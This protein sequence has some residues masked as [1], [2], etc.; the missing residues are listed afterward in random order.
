[1]GIAEAYRKN[2]HAIVTAYMKA[3]G[4]SLG[5]VSRKFH[6]NQAF[7]KGFFADDESR[8]VSVTIDKAEEMI[9]TLR[10]AWPK[11]VKWP[12]QNPIWM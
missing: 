11:D 12:A 8:R 3:T 7:L 9:E 1:M 6:G 2:L 5:T 10:A 4:L